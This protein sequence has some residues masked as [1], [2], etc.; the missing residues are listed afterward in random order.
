MTPQFNVSF[1]MT[2]GVRITHLLAFSGP[3]YPF[4]PPISSNTVSILTICIPITATSFASSQFL[5]CC[6][7]TAPLPPF[8]SRRGPRYVP[9][10]TLSSSWTDTVHHSVQIGNQVIAFG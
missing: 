5:Q 6:I 8:S 1:S 3:P 4:I 10:S 2:H 7:T 9:S